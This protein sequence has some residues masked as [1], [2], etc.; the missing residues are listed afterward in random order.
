VWDL[1]KGDEDGSLRDMVLM[2]DARACGYA[3]G[4]RRACTLT[5]SNTSPPTPGLG[6]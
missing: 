6:R 1:R 3:A 4:A 2:D 5:S